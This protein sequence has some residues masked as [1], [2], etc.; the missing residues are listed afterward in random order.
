MEALKAPVMATKQFQQLEEKLMAG[1]VPLS[2]TGVNDLGRC[3]MAD[4]I[5]RRYQKRLIVTYSED[6]AKKI[7][8]NYRF[9][10]KQVYLYPAKDALFYSADVHS[11]TIAKKR[12][13]IWKLLMEN[14]S[15]TVVL[16]V[17]ALLDKLPPMK[18]IKNNRFVIG[19]DTSIEMTKLKEKLIEL[20][21]EKR[22]WVEVAGQFAV[23]GGIFD[24]FPLT[25]E[26]PYRV[27][28]FGDDV[29]SIR[30][31]DVESQRS[32]E[33]VKEL[34]LY[35]AAEMVLSKSRIEKGIKAI[36]KEQKA[37]AKKL[38]DS[39]QTEAYAR[40][41]REMARIKE[42]LLELQNMDGLD[43]Y[44]EFFYDETVSFLDYFGEKGVVFLDDEERI[45]H[46]VNACREEFQSSMKS[47]LQ[48]GY[49]LPTQQN[50]LYTVEQLYE[51]LFQDTTVID[52]SLL[53]SK[54]QRYAQKES[55]NFLMKS[56]PSYQGQV[57]ELLKDMY[58]WRQEDYRILIIS[59]S[60]TRG[61]RL[62]ENFQRENIL[63]FFSDDKKRILAPREIMVTVGHLQEGF[64]LED[65]KLVV[66]SENDIMPQSSGNRR[67]Y[68]KRLYSGEQI[69]SFEDLSVGD[70]V[71]HE[72]Y[73]LGIY[74]GIETITVDDIDKDY[75][76]IEYQGGSKLY[77]LCSNLESI[78][79]YASAS[80]RP[81]KLNK[82]GGT[83]WSRTKGKVK[84]QIQQVA[85]ELVELYAARQ[86]TKGFAFSEDTV[87]QKEFEELFPYEETE[88]QL[89]AIEDTKKDMESDRIM[90]RLICGDVGFG[91]TEIAIRGA[92]KAVL[93]GKQVAYL[94]PTTIL[95]QQH[96]NSFVERMKEFPVKVRML[97]RFCTAK[98]QR[99]TLKALEKGEVDIV[100]GTHRLLSKDVAYKN[101]GLLIIDEEQRFGVTHKEKIKQLKKD[102]DV[103]TLTATPIPR[104]LHMSLI[105]IR[106]M[107]LLEE[108]PMD[109]RAIQTYVLEYNEEL[110]KEAISRELTRGGQVY[111][112]YNRV[113]SIDVI[114]MKL[115][116]LLPDARI[117]FAHGQMKERELENIMYRFINKEIDVLV[118][119]T[120]IE[121]GLDISNVNTMIIHDADKFGLSQ[122]YQLRGR[123]GRSNRNAYAF[124]MYKRDKQITEVAEKRLSAIREFTDL[125]SGIKIAKRDLEIR[126]AGNLLGHS[127]SGH[128]A[129]VG[130]D[131]YCKMLNEEVLRQ[132]GIHVEENLFETTL[133][134]PFDAMIPATYVKN[135]FV[136]L[137]LYKRIA[138]METEEDYEE[139]VDELLDRFGDLPKETR[140]LLDVALIKAKAHRAYVTEVAIKQENLRLTMYPKA[141]ID[142]DKIPDLF[143][144]YQGKMH[145]EQNPLPVFVVSLENMLKREQLPFI[146]EV[147]RD[148]LELLQ[149]RDVDGEP[150]D[151]EVIPAQDES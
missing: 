66:I 42:E 18:E 3:M 60:T 80:D 8:E 87:W 118:S 105:G 104:T 93:D 92:F 143:V 50:V 4:A 29:D 132:K 81:P 148:I 121:T 52:F 108:P 69:R 102:I 109:R 12:L 37:F 114:T 122:L 17:D 27:E 146:Q 110:V 113:S 72:Q 61:K 99:E 20:G 53:E 151:V 130:Y 134:I 62:A 77:V 126:G 41:N 5:G 76:S 30:S 19:M 25:E 2:I 31:F 144:K 67:K 128:M 139:M 94:V 32:I 35:P 98:E 133:D 79:K 129:A 10:D 107:S 68:K 55:Y 125:G 7:Y 74:Q 85:R 137:G 117:E 106:D 95:A 34:V 97:S 59:P 119:T 45:Y 64:V 40:V 100:I 111:Y 22:D 24:I 23:R 47:R 6:Q 149:N 13:E 56:V 75:I 101:L 82:L 103:L 43:N 88:D 112:V 65:A 131:L 86:E 83:E 1:E 9:F 138:N 48:G 11:N 14:Q 150:N 78:Q 147:I 120:I 135:E 54:K 90:D 141:P 49:I 142:V 21:Y 73:G 33:N 115:Q 145:L 15:I 36:E 57:Q 46:Q 44:V 140:N 136:K 84:E 70:Y 58:K 16:T 123:I 39:F 89:H 124:L 38:K 28:F 91:K 96:F 63:A 71:V 51:K 116:E 26:C 127:Q